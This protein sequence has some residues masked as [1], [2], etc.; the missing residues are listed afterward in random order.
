MLAREKRSAEGSA[1]AVRSGVAG[2]ARARAGGRAREPRRP[3]AV[4]LAAA[5][6]P[7]E[8][9]AAPFEPPHALHTPSIAA[10]G[11]DRVPLGRN[12]TQS[13]RTVQPK[14]ER[15][16][17]LDDA[18]RALGVRQILLVITTRA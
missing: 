6:A 13:L 3:V 16:P 17:I 12:L 1:G 8:A 2:A 10:A 4:T 11:D 18:R 7:I 9:G 15:I 14:L 5:D